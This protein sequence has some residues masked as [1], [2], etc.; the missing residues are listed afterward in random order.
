MPKGVKK[1]ISRLR[2]EVRKLQETK[3]DIN[4]FTGIVSGNYWTQTGMPWISG[5]G[6]KAVL[7]EYFWQPIRGQPRRVDTNELRQFSQSFWVNACVKTLIDEIASLDWDIVPKDEYEYAWVQ[8]AIFQVKEFLKFPNKNGESFNQI[9]RSLI[10]DVLEID[11]GCLVKVFDISSYDFNEIEP[12]SGAPMLKPFGQRKMLEIYCR[13]GSSFLKEIDKFGFIKG[14]W[15]YSYQIPAHPMWFNKEEVVYFSE[16]TRSMSCYGYARTQAILDIIKSLHYSTLYNKKFFEETAIPDGALSLLDTDEE[17]MSA[18][19]TY[20]NNEFKAQPHKVAV[21]NKDLKWQAFAATNQ[22]LEFLETQK[23]YFNLVVS[24]FGLTPAEMGITQDVNRATSA[25]QAELV[26]RKGIRPF[27]KL[28]EA[29]INEGI[30]KEFGFEGIEFQFIYDDPAE[31]NQRLTNW[32]MELSMGVKTI[33][34]V[35]DEMGLAPIE[36]GDRSNSMN[37]RFI[38][39][40]TPNEADTKTEGKVDDNQKKDNAEEHQSN[41]YDNVKEREE[42]NKKKTLENEEER[43]QRVRRPY[44]DSARP[45]GSFKTHKGQESID[46]PRALENPAGPVGMDTHYNAQPQ[47]DPG[48]T[49][50]SRTQ[51]LSLTTPEMDFDQEQVK[52]GIE[53]ESKEHPELEPEIIQRLVFDHLQENPTYY[54]QE[55]DNSNVSKGVDDGQYYREPQISMPNR[56][57]IF[58][59]QRRHDLGPNVAEPWDMNAYLP[60]HLGDSYAVPTMDTF[61]NKDTIHCPVCGQPTL[62]VLNSLEPMPED[63]R[64]TQCGSR[65]KTS[66]LINGKLMEEM[67]NVLQAHNAIEPISFPAR[68]TATVNWL[69]KSFQKNMDDFE[70]KDYCGFEVSKS[71]P[72]ISAFTDSREYQ[73]MLQ[74]YLSD[75]PKAKVNKIISILKNSIST[76]ETIS[77]VARKIDSIVKDM[78]RSKNIAR[79]EIVRISNEGNRLRMEEKGVSKVEYI[80]APEDGRLCEQCKSLN[81]KVF[82]IKEIK[83]VIPV[84]PHCRCLFTEVYD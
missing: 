13:D 49:T 1:E 38:V 75:L 66:D 68:G 12:K 64:C 62:T 69:G 46:F 67:N 24:M 84:H 9:L 73:K 77:D 11:A 37:D 70:V 48:I 80:S 56:G 45:V 83:N 78:Q 16:Q 28:F 5:E 6:R 15:Q 41:D 72:Q 65:F 52:R 57:N 39:P 4:A 43:K 71:L 19:R 82:S 3:K 23:W 32:Q 14:Y 59:P 30:I 47:A 8:E 2:S 27:L 21:I 31:K 25:T 26:K 17:E 36:G 7:T 20:W 61:E 51:D 58:Q 44:S 79:T 76:H 53:V 29:Y 22:E 81:G 63:F 35:R 10:K 42:N 34:E 74:K 60:S 55:G 33:N 54:S 50:R 40:G 18:F